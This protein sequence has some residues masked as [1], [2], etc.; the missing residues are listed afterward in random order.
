MSIRRRL[1]LALAALA[2]VGMWALVA[3][4]IDGL[5]PRYLESMEE[6]MVDTATILA[7]TVAQRVP[8]GS[9][10]P[11]PV[12]ELRAACAAAAGRRFTATIYGL[13]KE[14]VELRV[15]VVDARGIV[16]FDSDGGR[17]EG[18]DYSQWNDVMRIPVLR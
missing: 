13:I 17:D 12:A 18:R 1:L 10:A 16:V 3:W 7:E 4:L 2:A 15:Y 6:S 8:A 9:T 5:R 11:P 14:R